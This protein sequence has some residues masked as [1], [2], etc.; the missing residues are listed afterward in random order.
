MIDSK[1]YPDNQAISLP[2]KSLEITS[3]KK[4]ISKE[5]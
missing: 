3:E 2:T 5:S 1:M 4:A